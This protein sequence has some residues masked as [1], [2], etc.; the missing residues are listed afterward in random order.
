[1]PVTLTFGLHY[2]C[3]LLMAATRSFPVVGDHIAITSP[4]GKTATLP[5]DHIQ[6]QFIWVGPHR[7]HL[8]D[9]KARAPYTWML[10]GFKF[11]LVR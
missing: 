5:V 1:M 7:F 2:F 10:R 11:V 9:D 8:R 4:D 3:S 6:G